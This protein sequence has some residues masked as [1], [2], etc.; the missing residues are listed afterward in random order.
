MDTPSW[1]DEH[2]RLIAET[3]P[4]VP[5]PAEADAD[6]IWNLV[7]PDLVAVPARRNWRRTAIGAG[8]AAVVLGTSGIAAA[9]MLS[10]RTGVQET[11][12]ES[13]SLG[14]PGELID[15]RGGDIEQVIAEEIADIPFPSQQAHDIAVAD[16][17]TD[18]R[19]SAKSMRQ[20]QAKGRSDWREIWVTG[21]MRAEAARAAICAWANDWAAATRAGDGERRA[22]AIEMLQAAPS[23]PA[24]T[25]VDDEQ[26][27]TPSKH[28]VT[29]GD[30]V[31]REESFLDETPF[32]W[33][34]V[35]AK[36]ADGQD[37]RVLGRALGKGTACSSELV[38][39]LPS[40]LPAELRAR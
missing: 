30:G 28:L 36:A 5:P 4:P 18:A 14:G 20:A 9:Q 2:A 34:P 15:P 7:A 29:G 26:V 25:D 39:D 32:A 17:V 21:G 16:Q 38:R 22:E 11:D 13:I 1:T 10:A 27:Y 8:V 33:L 23:W 31:T 40:A 37:V 19:K 12:P 35:V 3:A 6:R 24:V